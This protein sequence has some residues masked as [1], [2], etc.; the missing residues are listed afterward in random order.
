MSKDERKKLYDAVMLLAAL[1]PAVYTMVA[2]HT[3][4]NSME[5]AR[6]QATK[7][8]D[9]AMAML[10]DKLSPAPGRPPTTDEPI[11]PVAPQPTPGEPIAGHEARPRPDAPITYEIGFDGLDMELT[12]RFNFE[13]SDV[14]GQVFLPYAPGVWKIRPEVARMV[15]DAL[16]QIKTAMVNSDEVV[17]GV[18]IYGV[19]DTLPIRT[20]RDGRPW[21]Y[22]GPLPPSTE[23]FD[24]HGRSRLIPLRNG[25]PL[26]NDGLAFLRAFAAATI[27]TEVFPGQPQLHAYT[28]DKVGDRYASIHIRIVNALLD[29]YREMN[30]LERNITSAGFA[31]RRAIERVR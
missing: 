16:R 2:F 17:V 23:A 1:I 26:T 28:S 13:D 31:V 24:Q 10:S 20:A 5:S 3:S 29:D 12:I 30:L 4:S 14:D 11:S 18:S 27:I 19:A 15:T 9:I 7:I 22:F 21:R 25:E 8:V 6:E